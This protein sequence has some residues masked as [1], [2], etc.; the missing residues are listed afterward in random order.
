MQAAK[1][2][3]KNKSDNFETMKNIV[4]VYTIN[5]E[6]VVQEEVII[7]PELHF[8]FFSEFTLQINLPEEESIILSCEEKPVHGFYDNSTDI[9]KR[10]NI[11]QY[12]HRSDSSFAGGKDVF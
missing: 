12:I 7:S 5:R 3:F 11:D 6:C 1:K 2:V 10:N 8:L 4:K 9:C